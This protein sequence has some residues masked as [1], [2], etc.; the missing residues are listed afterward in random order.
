MK[1]LQALLVVVT[2]LV[3]VSAHASG[4]SS[5]HSGGGMSHAT[6]ADIAKQRAALQASTAG[7]GFGP[8]APRDIGAKAGKNPRLFESAPAYTKMNLCNIHFHKNAE[9]KGGEFDKY[10]GPGDGHG[11]QGGYVYTGKLNAAQV[12]PLEA[13][14][15]KS[16]HGG[17]NAGDT[18]EVH[19]VHSTAAVKPG[20]TL[21]ACLS[22]TNKNPQLRVEAQIYVLVNDSKAADFGKLVEI[23]EANGYHQA[24]NIPSNTGTPVQYAGSTTGPSYNEQGSP[25]QVSWAVRP[26]V[27]KVDVQSVGRWC[28][29]NVFGED[30][31]HGVRNLVENEQLLSVIR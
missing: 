13:D 19:Y 24:L 30:H 3:T 28:A 11:Y 7:K 25:F 10:A 21:G 22:E 8:Q 27:I 15:C 16:A 20:K 1:K 26:K 23:G 29:G 5:A 18:I 14:V 4:A 12:K 31:A 9:H 6:D 17:V 2:S